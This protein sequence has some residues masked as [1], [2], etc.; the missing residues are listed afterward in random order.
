MKSSGLLLFLIFSASTVIAQKQE[1]AEKDTSA[2]FKKL[3][4]QIEV[5]QRELELESGS[6]GEHEVDLSGNEMPS[7][8]GESS[9]HVLARPWFQNIDISG[10]GA[11]GFLDTGAEGTRPA[12]GFLLKEASLFAEMDV[13]ERATVYL[14]IQT[15]RLGDDKTKF[16]RTGEVYAHFRDVLKKWGDD[17]LGIKLGRIDIPFGEEYLWQ[18]ASDNLLISNSA[19]YPYGWDEG[20]LLYGKIHSVGWIAALSDGTDERSIEDDPSKAVNLKVYG[21]PWQPLYLS[22]SFMKNGKAAKS[23]L[24]F[25]GSHFQPVGAS[26]ESS[27]GI[28]PSDKVDAVL[29]ELDAKYRF[30]NFGENGHLALSYGKA[31][32]DDPAPTFDRDLIWFTVEPL[33]NITRQAYA[34]M[35]YSEIGTYDSDKGYH[36][37]GKTTA[38]GNS[39]FGYDTRRLRRLSLGLGWRPN[40]RTIVKLEVGS[41]W[42]DVIDVS[43]LDA[44]DDK[45]NLFGLEM[46]LR[47]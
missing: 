6:N 8:E 11:A 3:K 44:K 14:E 24:E 19:A 26:H 27:I 15:N 35:R 5:L 17:L 37:D 23:A 42:F 41:D 22:A 45:R 13:W 47:F 20:V 30:G 21:N 7:I 28:S 10:F 9:T 46:A 18:D 31:F 25:G 39:A 33:Y 16:V 4:E 29:Y 34:V 38:G 2:Q 32:Q 40:P 1:V 36:F 12:G 43:P